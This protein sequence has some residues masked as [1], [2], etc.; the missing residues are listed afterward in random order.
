[1]GTDCFYEGQ[2]RLDGALCEYSEAD[3]FAFLQVR[4]AAQ[5]LVPGRPPRALSLVVRARK[6]SSWP[7]SWANFSFF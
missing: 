5:G 6:T 1:M 3:K 2:A 7:R 4:A